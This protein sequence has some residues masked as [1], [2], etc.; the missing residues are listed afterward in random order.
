MIL[1]LRLEHSDILK[2][3]KQLSLIC[4]ILI[5]TFLFAKVME[6]IILK[7]FGNF[8][9][10]IKYPII[11]P[12]AAL[13]F[14][15]L[16][17]RRLSLFFSCVLSII[18]N[19][20]L[21][22]EPPNAFLIINFV[23]SLIVIFSTQIMRKRTEVFEVCAKSMLGLI[24]VIFSV[25]FIKNRLFHMVIVED[26][27]SALIY[28]LIIAIMVVSLLPILEAIFDVLT[29]ITL[30][31]YMDPNNELLRRITL[32]VPGSYQHS[33]VLGNLSEAAAQKINANT[34]FCRVA[35][36]Y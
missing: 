21:T 2:S 7:S 36:L 32:E 17:N 20:V 35:T 19:L 3:L 8:F 31:E 10:I 26:M 30:M 24:P 25:N 12:F 34:L 4:T 22:V 27:T 11:V 1:Y 33:L 6:L 29:D 14:S 18:L 28:L 23:T 15:I 13:L 5:L 9:L 16:F